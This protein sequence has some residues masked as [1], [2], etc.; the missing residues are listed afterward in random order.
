MEYKAAPWVLVV[1]GEVERN[2]T[3][4]MLIQEWTLIKRVKPLHIIIIKTN[5][6]RTNLTHQR[7][8]AF[9][10]FK[11][12]KLRTMGELHPSLLFHEFE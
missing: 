9:F 4:I 6:N 7:V 11:I 10:T 12:R 3:T 2:L 8:S 1:F 5:R